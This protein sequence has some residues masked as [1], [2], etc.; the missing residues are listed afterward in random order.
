ML[1]K[2]VWTTWPEIC[3]NTPYKST[4][5]G[6]GNGE[7]R[8]ALLMNGIVS[9]HSLSYDIKDS[10][11]NLWEVKEPT[12]TGVIRT[13]AK[14]TEV[15]SGILSKLSSVAD[16][17]IS[18]VSFIEKHNLSLEDIIDTQG[19]FSVKSFIMNDIALIKR[20][21]IP[22][23]RLWRLI[24]VMQAIRSSSNTKKEKIYITLTSSQGEKK[25]LVTEG[26]FIRINKILNVNIDFNVNNSDKKTELLSV[27]D[28][29][30]FSDP[31]AFAYEVWHAPASK[32]FLGVEGVIL[33]D[34]V[35]GYFII[36][37]DDLDKKLK[38]YAISQSSPR[39]KVNIK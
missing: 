22:T 2:N 13:G 5:A 21:E 6:I 25:F 39:Y 11:G 15:V 34:E 10:N 19:A 37:K 16:S 26:E 31:M 12:A 32:T 23:S 20:G 8:L 30:A 17:L 3:I 35:K 36:P 29:D 33:V 9:G 7:E 24:T 27:F 38:F 28:D 1:N 4:Q 18:G 14:G